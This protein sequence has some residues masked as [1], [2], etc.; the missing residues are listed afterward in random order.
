MLL[1]PFSFWDEKKFR[2]TGI[3]GN[4][5]SGDSTQ[6]I[7]LIVPGNLGNSPGA[8]KKEKSQDRELEPDEQRRQLT[9]YLRTG[10]PNPMNS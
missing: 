9:D 2:K 10:N 6:G 8:V 1:C 3:Q 7:P 5:H 4:R